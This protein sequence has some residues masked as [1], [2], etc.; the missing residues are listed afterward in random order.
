MSR[1]P[2]NPPEVLK[3]PEGRHGRAALESKSLTFLRGRRAVLRDVAFTIQAG[4]IVALLGANGAGKTTLLD[5]LAGQLRPSAGE[6]LW[7]GEPA[8]RSPAAKRRIG[9]LPHETGLYLELTT[10]ENLLFAARMHGLP[11]G[12]DR[13]AELLALVGLERK[14]GQPVQRLSLGMRRRLAIARAVI[15]EPPILLLDE[16]FANLD[17]ECRCWLSRFLDELR[18]A[19]AAICFT[20]HD[21]EHCRKIAD[22]LV[23]LEAGRLTAVHDEPGFTG[24]L[25]IFP[26]SA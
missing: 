22:R 25:L 17:D 18:L 24:R 14:A 7:L 19:G 2:A 1:T 23:R 20:S 4:E 15:H 10:Q 26:R 21:L 6:V 3:L 16:P 5:C 9:Y 12:A 13:V 8:N 11:R